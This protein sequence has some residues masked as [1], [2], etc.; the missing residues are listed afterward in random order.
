MGNTQPTNQPICY[1]IPGLGV[2]GMVFQRLKQEIPLQVIEWK[3]PEENESVE[4]Y[5]SRMAEEIRHDRVIL[6]GYS[7]GG[8]IAQEI[9]RTRQIQ[10]LILIN[11]LCQ[12]SEKPF[13]LRLMKRIPLYKLARGNWRIKLLPVYGRSFGVREKEDVE[14]LTRMFRRAD[15]RVRMWSAARLAHWTRLE[16]SRMAPT[17]RLHGTRDRV[18]PM[19][20]ISDPGI[21]RIEGGAHFMIWQRSTEIAMIIKKWIASLPDQD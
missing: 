9:A 1:A 3:L 14:A 19:N 8:V 13:L 2:D 6:I 17:I 15:N 10:G 12:T 4:S 20:Q 16:L 11:T 18:F 5:A 7:F 21:H